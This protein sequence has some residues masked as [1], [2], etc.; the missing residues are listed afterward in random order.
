[1]NPLVERHRDKIAGVLSCFDRVV[2]TGTLPDIGYAGAMAG[3]L[4]YHKIRLFD[5]PRWPEPLRDELRDHAEQLASEA[6]IEIEFIRRHKAFRKEDRIKAIITGRGD[7]PGLVHIFSAMEA[8]TAYRPWHDKEKG[9]TTLKPTSGKCLHY[10][11]YFID[12]SFGLCYV[13]V[14]TWA[15]FRLQV[16]FNGHHWLAQRLLK[17]G[18]SFEMADNAFL[19]IADP[20]HAQTLADRLD[21]KQLHRRLNRWPNQFCPV[22]QRFRSGYHWSLMQVEFAN[23]VV[24]LQQAEFQP[25]YES[26]IRTGVQVIKADNV[27]TFLGRKLTNAYQGEVGNNF[28]TR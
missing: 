2:I 15:P 13:R 25:L 4:S 14:P 8:C 19:S 28:S 22:H 5:Y 27:A 11:F 23:D 1:M 26:I 3:Y 9:H 17:A 20:K 18:I 16:Y 24:F 6:G 12:E 7:H 21:A 10:C